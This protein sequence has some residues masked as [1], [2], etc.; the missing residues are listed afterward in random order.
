MT[1]MKESRQKTKTPSRKLKINW[2]QEEQEMWG[3]YEPIKA[4]DPSPVPVPM[5][6]RRFLTHNIDEAGGIFRCG[7]SWPSPSLE[8]L[9]I[10]EQ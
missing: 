3:K 6:L 4:S 1:Q 8:P 7:A 9:Y 5:N 2:K 10:V